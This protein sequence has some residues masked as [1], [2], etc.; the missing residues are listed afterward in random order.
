MKCSFFEKVRFWLFVSRAFSLPMSFFAWMVAFIFALFHAGSLFYGLLALIGVL[1]GHLGVNLFDDYLDYRLHLKTQ[2]PLY[3]GKCE[4]LKD[5]SITLERLFD[6]VMV[7]FSI[8]IFIGLYFYLVYGVAILFIAGFTALLSLFYPRATFYG[9]GEI[10][11]GV[12][13]GPLLM[14]SVYYVM[15]GVFSPELFGISISVGI[16]TVLLTAVHSFMDFKR[17]L[18]MD[19]KTLCTVMA[20]PLKSLVLIE[21]LTLLA[22]F[23]IVFLVFQQVFEPVFLITLFAVFPAILLFVNLSKHLETMEFLPENYFKNLISARNV[24]VIF[25]LLLIVAITIFYLC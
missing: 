15:C 5:G 12:M 13:F 11:V 9:L 22:F 23:N 20:S 17:D 7:C 24:C 21:F 25:N 1:F 6:A 10:T 2:K 8:S 19:K 14:L 18:F 16:L 4:Y 3:E